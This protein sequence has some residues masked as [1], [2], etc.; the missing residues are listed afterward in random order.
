MV[1]QILPEGGNP[2][3]SL[4]AKVH[5]ISAHFDTLV[6][7]ADSDIEAVNAWTSD[8]K[9]SGSVRRRD[10]ELYHLRQ[11]R[12]QALHSKKFVLETLGYPPEPLENPPE[13]PTK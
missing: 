4:D 2:P 11:K 5:R 13:D 10:Q 3:E 7:Q 6:D 12:S 1:E 8:V 9:T